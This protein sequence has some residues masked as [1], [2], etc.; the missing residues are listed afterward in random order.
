MNRNIEK[1]LANMQIEEAKQ[2]ILAYEQE[3][4]GDTD[5]VNY[6]LMCSILEGK[7]QEA[8]GYAEQTVK[9]Q[10]YV[11]D[12]HYNCGYAYQMQGRL[13]EAYEQYAIARELHLG[14]N[15]GSF[16]LDELEQ[17]MEQVLQV[18]VE[19]SEKDFQRYSAEVK[20]WLSYI[21]VQEKLHWE[22]RTSTFHN[23]SAVI[24]MEYVDY[25]YL[26]KAFLGIAGMQSVFHRRL[27]RLASNTYLEMI[28][29]QRVTEPQNKVDFVLDQASFV[30]IIMEQSDTIRVNANDKV[31]PIAYNAPLQYVY[32]RMPEGKIKIQSD[33]E[34]F[35]MG[36]MI[37]IEHNKKRKKLVLNLFIDGLSQTVL[38]EQMSQLMPYTYRFFEKGMC[39]TNVHTAGDWTF[40]SI[41]AITTG[42]SLPRH[43][44]LHSKLLH[45]IDPMTPLLSEYFQQAGYHTV[46]IGGNWRIAPNYGYGR[47]HDQVFYQHMYEGLTAEKVISLVEEQMYHMREVDQYIWMEIGELHTIADECNM[48]PLQMEFP[49]QQLTGS[50][51]KVNSVKQNYDEAK[52]RYYLEQISYLDRKL[53]GLYQYI[54]DH[55]SDEEV[56]VSLFADHG[57][58]YLVKPDSEFLCDERTNIA[59]MTRG[60]G[61][62]GESQE[63]IS[64][65]DYAPI[66]CSLAGIPY[67]YEN[68]D[69]RLP[70]T[71]GGDTER[72]FAV[73]E[74]I[75]V[76]DPYQIVLNGK[77]FVFYLK[78]EENVTSEC[79]VP[80]GPYS[81]S[82]TDREGNVMDDAA[83][84]EELT[85]WCLQHIAPCVQY[86][87]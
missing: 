69:A 72:E 82:L 4:P 14:G 51:G 34:P 27:G 44:M 33:K 64:S 31:L 8:V 9:N 81:V 57:Q 50:T 52:K 74:S 5:I 35:R 83:K 20:N 71:Y 66:M 47:G 54:E 17:E 61:V 36:K 32:Y 46:K 2:E 63:I 67:K 39:C 24:G 73:T 7:G 38:G 59:F 28:E 84:K 16:S 6:R 48:A 78:G 21:V 62:S 42:Q 68:T 70:V 75:H 41:A 60:G 86:D 55:Y 37:P 15:E 23:G 49:I 11:S 76:G 80:Q 79:R 18:I 45:K 19:G 26:N 30:P 13:L 29:M 22:L 3:V 56:V 10:P 85:K 1:L 65:C 87:N 12:V 58:G 77:D 53:A 43:K 25:P 40:P